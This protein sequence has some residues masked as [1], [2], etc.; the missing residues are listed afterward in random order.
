MRAEAVAPVGVERKGVRLAIGV[1]GI[2]I[3][4]MAFQWP[5]A[6]LSAV[7]TAMFLRA[8]APPS[9]ADGVRLVLL[10]FALLI[11]GYGPFSI[12]RPDRP[13]IVIAQ[14]LLLMGAFWLSVTGKSPL[15]VVLALLEAVLMPYLVHLSLDLAHS[16][17][18][19]LPTNMGFVLLAT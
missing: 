1:A 18:S 15:L 3:T 17:G 11:F 7:F 10:A 2:F 14:I 19:W 6:F 5:F 16:F 4:A 13:N 12:L 9:I 8:P